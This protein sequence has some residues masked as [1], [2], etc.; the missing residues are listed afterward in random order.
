MHFVLSLIFLCLSP[1]LASAKFVDYVTVQGQVSENGKTLANFEYHNSGQIAKAIRGDNVESFEW[2]G[3]ALI[4]RGGIKYINEPHA[5]GGNPVLGISGENIDAIFNDVLGTSLGIIKG[6]GYSAIDKTSFGDD[7]EDKRLFF[8]GKPYVEDLGYTFLFRNYR[9]DLGKWQ[10]RDLI[11][12]PNGWNNF[13]YCGNMPRVRFDLLG[14]SWD[15]LDMFNYAYRNDSEP[16][17]ID[18][19]RMGV[20]DDVWRNIENN[21]IPNMKS[22]IDYKVKSAVSSESAP[23]GNK[24]FSMQYDTD[25]SYSFG[26]VIWAMGDGTVKTYSS[27]SYSWTS[28]T[29][30][31]KIFINY[32]WNTTTTVVYSDKFVDIFDT[33]TWLGMNLDPRL[34]KPYDYGHT[35]FKEFDGSGTIVREE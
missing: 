2:D 10:M 34:M 4:E 31:N 35:W 28:S 23:S 20:T 9:A 15:S 3:L 21:V 6:G 8:T 33:E 1:L 7:I 14:A 13:A 22:Q 17:Y 25:R 26:N 30:E 29:L 16:D 12:Y 18:T 32:V 19:D 5:G 11:G 27:I 24:P